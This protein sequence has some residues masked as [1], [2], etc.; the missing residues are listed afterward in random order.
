VC[1]I[2]ECDSCSTQGFNVRRQKTATV[3]AAS[4]IAAA[5]AECF[6]EMSVCVCVCVCVC[7]FAARGL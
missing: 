1:V 7:V 5:V 6:K 3:V 4:D 2:D